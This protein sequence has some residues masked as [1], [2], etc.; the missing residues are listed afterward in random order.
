MEQHQRLN[1]VSRILDRLACPLCL[2]VLALQ[3]DRLLCRSCG[4]RFSIINGIPDLRPSVQEKAESVDWSRHWSHDHQKTIAQRFFSFYRKAVFA[5][6]VHYFVDRFFPARGVFVEAGS[7]T[8]ETSLRVN[9]RNGTRLLVAV[10]IVLPILERCQ[11]VMDVK[12]CGDIF[13][14]PFRT[15]SVDGIWNVGVMEHFKHDQIDAIMREFHRV[16]KCGG[17]AI[18][19][20]PGIDSVPQK[21]LKISAK[22]I[23]VMSGEKNFQFH[24]DEISQLKSLQEG[25]EVLVRNG[26]STL[27]L[28]SGL[29]SL[30]AFKIL[31]GQKSHGTES[32]GTEKGDQLWLKSA[33]LSPRK[34]KKKHFPWFC[35]IFSKRFRN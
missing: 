25:N 15:E 34:T 20:W 16:L 32:S 19:L 35:G 18:L 31:V 27:R 33:S 8:A 10:D 3:E 26:F 24:P 21:M 23:Q 5:R 7:G 2:S 4:V 28:D 13:R 29:R 1:G 11:P 14:L 30:M 9:K 17:A 12:V 22:I 6:T